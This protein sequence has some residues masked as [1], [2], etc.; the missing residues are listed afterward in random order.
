MWLSSKG[1]ID[2]SKQPVDRFPVPCTP[3]AAQDAFRTMAVA[4]K[5]KCYVITERVTL[6]G[7]GQT[8]ITNTQRCDVP[9][10]SY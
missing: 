8:H 1:V 3:L 5:Q 2:N 10:L 6:Q 4:N 7:R 9:H